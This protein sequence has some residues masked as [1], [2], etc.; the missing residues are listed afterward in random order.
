MFEVHSAD[1]VYPDLSAREALAK[2]RSLRRSGLNEVLI[3]QADGTRISQYALTKLA[4]RKAEG[5]A[6]A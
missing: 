6:E 5:A 2:A 3:F 4:Q 1:G